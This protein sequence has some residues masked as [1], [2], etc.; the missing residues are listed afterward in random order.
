[1]PVD[2]LLAKVDGVYNAV[3]LDTDVAGRLLFYGPG[4]GPEPT[5]SALISDVLRI[6]K[7]LELGQYFSWTSVSSSGKNIAPMAGIESQFYV[8]MIVNDSYGVL[9]QI[10][11]IFKESRIS[12]LSVIQKRVDAA[13]QTAEI[14]LMTHPAIEQAMQNSLSRMERLE[15][16]KEIGNVIRV[17]G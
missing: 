8:R 16:V 5:S 4:A 2:L 10:T 14:V 9:A 1:M 7:S 15:A 13:A 12:L 3:Q 6:V 17:E 11:Q